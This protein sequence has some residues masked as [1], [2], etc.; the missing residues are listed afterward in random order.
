MTCFNDKIIA[1]TSGLVLL[2]MVRYFAFG[3]RN[4]PLNLILLVSAAAM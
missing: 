4:C 2:V 1:V 3:T